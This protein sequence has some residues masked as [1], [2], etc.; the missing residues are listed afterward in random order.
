MDQGSR[1]GFHRG[2][3]WAPFCSATFC[4]V[5]GGGDWFSPVVFTRDGLS[6]LLDARHLPTELHEQLPPEHLRLSRRLR[7][8]AVKRTHLVCHLSVEPLRVL[9]SLEALPVFPRKKK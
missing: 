9:K 1:R 4:S 3:L 6:A 2:Y 7:L 5:A 8:T